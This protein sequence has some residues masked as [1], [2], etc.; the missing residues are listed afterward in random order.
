MSPKPD[1]LDALIPKIP[2]KRTP[3]APHLPAGRTGSYFIRGLV[4]DT[5]SSPKSERVALVCPK[6]RGLPTRITYA[7]ERSKKRPDREI[8]YRSVPCV[9]TYEC[10]RR[11][12]ERSRR[13]RRGCSGLHD[14]ACTA[15]VGRRLPR[16]TFACRARPRPRR[17]SHSFTRAAT[18]RKPL[19][20]SR[21]NVVRLTY[22]GKLRA[23]LR[24]LP[25]C[26]HQSSVRPPYVRSKCRAKARP[27][28]SIPSVW[29]RLSREGR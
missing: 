2:T 27:L 20:N 5:S 28:A 22:V 10:R 13:A 25:S 3:P 18:C 24:H 26:W 19:A 12:A 16:L 4:L 7:Q 1:N 21:S 11:T 29:M 23:S 14:P 8:Q 15:R 6:Q 17:Q 9:R